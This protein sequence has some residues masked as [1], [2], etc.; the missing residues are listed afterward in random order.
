MEL[1]RVRD[2]EPGSSA[3]TRTLSWRPGPGQGPEQEDVAGRRATLA[4]ERRV[5]GQQARD[6]HRGWRRARSLR[7]GLSR[8]C[9]QHQPA[10]GWQ[11]ICGPR[12][13]RNN[14]QRSRRNT[15][16]REATVTG[17]VTAGRGAL[18]MGIWTMGKKEEDSSGRA[19]K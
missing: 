1:G 17:L 18:A 16:E 19:L 14:E 12:R 8:S 4:G 11:R 6:E 3:M 7:E 2:R 15:C 13:T 10:P 9:G 5:V